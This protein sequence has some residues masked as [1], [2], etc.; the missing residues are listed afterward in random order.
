MDREQAKAKLNSIFHDIFE[1][2][3]IEIYDEMTAKNVEGWDSLAHI[4]L[5]IAVEKM[6]K[7]RFDTAETGSLENVGSLLGAIVEKTRLS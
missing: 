5:I 6:F 2:E 7:I 3:S 4:K 1:D